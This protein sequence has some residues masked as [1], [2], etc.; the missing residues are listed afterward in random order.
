MNSPTDPSDL[1]GRVSGRVYT[2]NDAGFAQE[3][4]AFNTVAVH[5][6]D[7]VVAAQ[8]ASDVVEAVRFAAGRGYRVHV[9]GAGH[10]AHAA[11]TSGL[12][13]STRHLDRVSID[14]ATRIA[15][16][17]AGARWAPVV[18]AAAEHGLAP[19]AGSSTNVGVVGYSLAGGLGP[20]AR[21]H[22]F[23][24]DYLVGATV[25]TGAGELVEA[26][27]QQNPELFWALRGGRDGL[28]IVT[29]VRVRLVEL[30]TL[31]A[32]SLFFDEPHIE[33][34][35]R[36]WVDWTAKAD[37]QVTTSIAI[38]RF[39]SLE[40][41]PA[42]FRGR[43]LLGLRF[44]YPGALDEGAR[45][46]APLRAAAPIYLDALGALPAAEIA[47]IHND[48]SSPVPSW[49]T[50]MLLT[51]VDQALATALL[52]QVGAGTDAPFIALEVRHLGEA[53]KRD[54]EGGSAVGGRGGAFALTLVGIPRPE[55][56]HTAVPAGARRLREAVRPWTSPETNINLVGNCPEHYTSAWPEETRARLAEVRRRY[57][58]KAVFAS[59]Q[60]E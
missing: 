59:K 57:D 11:I 17:G 39:P 31:Y 40:V 1:A 51:H 34:A 9:Q 2:A 33:A 35:L 13:I 44:A 23:S 27:A 3:I 29:E 38:V 47:R 52:A 43:R 19:I 16:I 4:A 21:S 30:R 55:L 32:G 42:P 26:S 18:A 15:T 48:P 41:V 22:G 36:A 5:T 45:L 7:L 53:T 14:P 58:P 37:P 60:S 46:A 10:G 54:V 49:V 20:L 24:S 12:L 50:G 25:V 8:S 56:F 28:G 6:P